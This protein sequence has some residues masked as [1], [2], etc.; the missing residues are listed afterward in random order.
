MEVRNGIETGTLY[1][2]GNKQYFND[3]VVVK[4]YADEKVIDLL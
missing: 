4:K 2:R 1:W 3:I